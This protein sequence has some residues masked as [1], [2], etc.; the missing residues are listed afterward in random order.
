MQPSCLCTDDLH[1]GIAECFE[2][3]SDAESPA[4]AFK[5]MQQA[6]LTGAFV[7]PLQ[8]SQLGPL[9]E[10]SMLICATPAYEQQCGALGVTFEPITLAGG[11]RALVTSS[12]A[13]VGVVCVAMAAL[14]AL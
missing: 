5:E 8:S 13:I 10:I 9:S 6:S 3:V 14:Y 7:R 2:C 11:A 12:T 4:E 1:E